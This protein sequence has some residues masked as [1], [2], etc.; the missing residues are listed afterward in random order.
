ML[1]PPVPIPD[2]LWGDRWRFASILAGDF[3]DLFLDRPIPLSFL[4]EMHDPLRVGLASSQPLPGVVI[5][6]G[7]KSM[8][9]ARWLAGVD[10][11]AVNYVAGE[12]DGVILRAGERDRHI[13]TTV[14]DPEVR[15]AGEMFME[16][17]QAA[18]GLH[19]LLIQPDDSGMTYTSVW[20]LRDPEVA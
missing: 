1:N 4:P 18:K 12:L 10:P 6:G 7:R 17:K 16:R 20:L 11:I 5:N 9:L 19:F 8:P 13:L 2:T 15:T 3:L 14:A